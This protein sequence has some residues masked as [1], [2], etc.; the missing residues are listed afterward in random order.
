ML[1]LARAPA[2]RG[3]ADAAVGRLGDAAL[4]AVRLLPGHPADLG[5]PPQILF[6]ASPVDRSRQHRAGEAE[7]DAAAPLHGQPAGDRPSAVPP[8]DHQP[9]DAERPRACWLGTRAAR[10][11]RA[12]RWRS[13]CSASWSST[14]PRRTWPRT[15]EEALATAGVATSLRNR[16]SASMRVLP[17]VVGGGRAPARPSRARS[18]ASREDGLRARR[19]PP[20]V[21]ARASGSCRRRRRSHGCRG[22]RCRRRRSPPPSPRAPAGRSPRASRSARTPWPR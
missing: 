4:V 16:S 17:R 14:G 15:C 22:R 9:R 13:S 8:R 19:P 1:T 3:D 10:A 12:R 6:Y 5:R 11:D 18:S 21:P 20:P 2:D 7:P